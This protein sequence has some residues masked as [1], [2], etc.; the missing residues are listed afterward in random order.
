VEIFARPAVEVEKRLLEA[1]N[2][3]TSD[4][5]AEHVTE[6]FGCGSRQAPD[7]VVGSR[8]TQRA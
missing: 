6:F 5:T 1:A 4:L 2:L 7:G 3:P 8:G